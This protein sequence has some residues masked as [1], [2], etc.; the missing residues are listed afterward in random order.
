MKRIASFLLCALLLAGLAGCAAGPADAAVTFTDSTGAEISLPG[1]PERVAVLFSS[2]AEI[3]TLAGGEIA[4]TVGETVERGFA[5]E[6]VTLVDA[7][8]GHSTLDTEALVA[9]E[10]ELVIGTADYPCQ[11]EACLACRAAGIPA[12][13]F[14]E[15]SFADYLD[16]LTLFCELCGST[17]PLTRFGS[18]VA[19]AREA[20]LREAED[21]PPR[22]I[23]LLRAGA[24]ARSVKAKGSA[25][26]I[27]GGMLAELGQINLADEAP[28]LLDGL[29][30]ETILLDEPDRILIVPMG[31]EAESRACVEELFQS[32]GWRELACVQ[33]GRT[34]FLPKELFHYK[35][36]AR[37][38]EAEAYLIDLMYPEDES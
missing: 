1:R 22:R 26:L 12:A 16:L 14:R 15:E 10:P 36:N 27:V 32:P 4:V 38:A 3:W 24:S 34:D 20:I 21:L 5:P 30:L 31:D 18:D 35:P 6:S 11:T 33:E 2:Y 28:V 7:G 13:L 25:D 29:S 17:E 37:W 23:L 9:A 19:A 8:A